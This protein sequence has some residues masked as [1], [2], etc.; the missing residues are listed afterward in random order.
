MIYINIR[1]TN[2]RFE[3][4]SQTDLFLKVICLTETWFSDRNCESSL[5][6]V[7]QYTAN[8]QHRSPSHKSAQE[9][10]GRGGGVS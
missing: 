1:N 3:K 5:Y 9:G 6:Q 4:L 8:H 2:K 10:R 7:P